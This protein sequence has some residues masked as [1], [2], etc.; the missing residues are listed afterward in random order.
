MRKRLSRVEYIK[1]FSRVSRFDYQ[2]LE[3]IRKKYG[4]KSNYQ[5]LQYLLHCFLRTADP[6]NDQQIEPVPEEIKEMFGDLAELEKHFEYKKPK[7]R[8]SRKTL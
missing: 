2:R 7:R 8:C 6:D 5:I 3:K 4:F 1:I